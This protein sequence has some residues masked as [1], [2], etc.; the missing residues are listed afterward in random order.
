MAEPIDKLDSDAVSRLVDAQMSL[1]NKMLRFLKKNFD[2]ILVISFLIAII[3]VLAYLFNSGFDNPTT[4]I[5]GT[6]LMGLKIPKGA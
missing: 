1:P 4:K 2:I 3:S 6:N 5:G